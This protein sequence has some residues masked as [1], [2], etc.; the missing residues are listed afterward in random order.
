M[1]GGP[2]I[3][4]RQNLKAKEYLIMRRFLHS[5]FP[6][7]L[8]STSVGQI[9]AFTMFSSDISSRIGSQQAHVQ[10]AFSLGIFFL[11]MGAA[12]FGKIVEKNIKASS[13][14]GTILFLTGLCV[15][16]IGIRASSLWT[17]LTGYG[18]LLG[19][20]TGVIYISPVKTLMLWFEKNKGLASAVPIISFG[21]GSSLC[22]LLSHVLAS[23][24]GA[25]IDTIFFYLAAIYAIPMILGIIFLK[26]PAPESTSKGKT[27]CGEDE[28]S[29]I[30]L[31]KD[32]WFL[33]AWLFM[34]LN[35]SCGLSLIPLSKQFL[36]ESG[37]NGGFILTVISICG[38][39]NGGGRLLFAF[40]SDLLK[41]R[42]NILYVILG[43]SILVSATAFHPIMIPVLLLLI[44]ACYGA[45]FS[46]I[47]SILSDHYGMGN[48]SKIHGAVLSAWGFAGLIGNQIS[49]FIHKNYGIRSVLAMLL[50]LYIFNFLN[51][52]TLNRSKTKIDA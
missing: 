24:A 3:D 27:S 7:L 47:P 34:L 46:T 23:R 25:T 8:L 45:G 19:L 29:Y 31:I 12:F 35:I 44:N 5:V 42:S 37:F 48:I 38:V 21:L 49:I 15:T 16:Q 36:S 26:K 2:A 11:G 20:G 33:R 28:F 39:M 6:A 32:T 40:A 14:L 30:N 17:I 1:N 4:G 18:F 41:K 9:Y 51:V 13:I 50:I 43:I 52:W 22:A 10:M